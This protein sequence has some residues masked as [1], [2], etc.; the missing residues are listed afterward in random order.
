MARCGSCGGRKRVVKPQ[1]TNTVDP[2][3]AIYAAA[4]PRYAVTIGGSTT[5]KTFSTYAAAA[6]YAR[7]RGGT[8]RPA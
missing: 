8:V 3:K 4:M 1:P 5:G 2:T 6:D 7:R